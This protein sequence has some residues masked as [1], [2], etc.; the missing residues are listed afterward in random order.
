MVAP[1]GHRHDVI[2]NAVALFERTRAVEAAAAFATQKRHA[3][4]AAGS[5][6][7]ARDV[8]RRATDREGMT[9]DLFGKQRLEQVA[10]CAALEDLQ[11][12]LCSGGCAARCAR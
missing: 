12:S 7:L 6:L 9:E 10:G 8:S 1:E 3:H 2:H 4:V 5:E 11:T